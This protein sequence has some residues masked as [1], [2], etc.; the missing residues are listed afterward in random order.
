MDKN[1]KWTIGDSV[2]EQTGYQISDQ[3][4]DPEMLALTV[5]QEKLC[6]VIVVVA[7]K[8]F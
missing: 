3:M 4:F 7:V 5:M 1:F 6:F 2:E 8:S